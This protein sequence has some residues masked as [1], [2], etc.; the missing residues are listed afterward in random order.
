MLNCRT[1]EHRYVEVEAPGPGEA[2]QKVM[3]R[4]AF[5]RDL[6]LGDPYEFRVTSPQEQMRAERPWQMDATKYTLIPVVRNRH[7]PSCAKQPW[8]EGKGA[9]CTCG[10]SL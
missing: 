3:R 4:K 8:N 2:L 10:A 1:G 9:A 7:R 5:L 6:A